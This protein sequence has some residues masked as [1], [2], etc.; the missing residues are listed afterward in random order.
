[1]IIKILS[2]AQNGADLGGLEAAKEVGFPTGGIMP[3][4]F[5]NHDGNHPEWAEL[6][7]VT[8]HSSPKYPPRTFENVKNSDATLR[9]AVD[10][11]TAG[12]RCTLK[13][14]Q[15]YDKPYLDIK[16]TRDE[17]FEPT[18]KSVR[19]VVDWICLNNI[20][21]LNIAGNSNKTYDMMQVKVKNFLIEVF[22]KLKE[23]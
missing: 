5:Y 1:M 6:Y 9:F 8:E 19:F 17:V 13:A 18:D 15:Q 14:I 16:I 3:K 23:V 4:G 12:E 21:I 22:K 20:K 11:S 10:F 2:G 7:G